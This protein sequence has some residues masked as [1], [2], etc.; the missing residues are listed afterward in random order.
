MFVNIERNGTWGTAAELPGL[1]RLNG[2]D[3]AG[4]PVLSCGARGDCSLGGFYR[5]GRL[6]KPYL[7]TQKNGIWG[8]AAAVKGIEP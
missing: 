8:D 2:G 1:A 5:S 7:A 3:R 4:P 6:S